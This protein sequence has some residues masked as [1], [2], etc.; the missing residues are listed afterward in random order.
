MNVRVNVMLDTR[1]QTRLQEVLRRESRS[2]LQYVSDSFPW[3][4]PEE[5]D[6]LAQVRTLIDEERIAIALFAKYLV[7]QHIPLPYL[8]PYPVAFTTLNFVTLDHLLPLLVDWE[9]QS[10]LDLEHDSDSFTDAACRR[11]MEKLLTL[12]QQHLK[13]LEA[14]TTAHPEMVSR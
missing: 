14:L 5:N 10:I 3:T 1:T 12:K 13:T 4:N 6:A 11:E 8:E 7:R 9:R 2:F